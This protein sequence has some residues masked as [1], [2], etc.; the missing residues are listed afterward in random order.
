MG[1]AQLW[2]RPSPRPGAR[3]EGQDAADA[4]QALPQRL[5]GQEGQLGSVLQG[6]HSQDP[7]APGWP[8]GVGLWVRILSWHWTKMTENSTFEC[9]LEGVKPR[10]GLIID[11]VMEN[12]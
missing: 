1:A 12:K 8:V 4:A 6:Q 7:P 9:L 10:I 2:R 11:R 5:H 3:H